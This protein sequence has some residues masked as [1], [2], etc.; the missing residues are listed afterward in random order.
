MKKT[1]ICLSLLFAFSAMFAQSDAINKIFS[2]YEDDPA[3]TSVF[4]SPKMFEMLAQ[5]DIEV[6]GDDDAQ[7]AMD[8]ASDLTSVRVLTSEENGMKYYKEVMGKLNLSG[9]ETLVR[10]NEKEE[11]VQIYVKEKGNTIS[12]LLVLVGEVS[13]FVLVSIVGDIDLDKISKLSKSSS[14]GEDFHLDKLKKVEEKH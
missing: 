9:Y 7:A 8:I 11:N 12:E 2:Q 10:V 1:V 14:F 13:E 3:F 4:V 5:M 6:D